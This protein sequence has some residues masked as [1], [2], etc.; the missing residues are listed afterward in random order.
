MVTLT[1]ADN[2]LKSLYLEALS[3]QLNTTTNPL[4]NK[5]VSTERD[6]WGKEIIKLAP[7]GMNGGI[8]AGTETGDLPASAGNNYKQFKQT[9]KNLYGTIEIS[10]KAIRASA[11]N[12]GAFLSLLDAEMDGLLAASKFNFGRMLF[13]SGN[14]VLTAVASVS[15]N[16]VVVDS[17]QYLMEGM[18][19]DFL[20]SGTAVTSYTGRRIT[21][22]DRT[23]CTITI[24]GTA[25]VEGE[26]V[27]D[28]QIT[29]QGSYNNELTGLEAIFDSDITSLYGL[30]KADNPWL[31]PYTDTVT[32]ITETEIQTVID[33][34]ESFSGSTADYIVC[35]YGV[36]R[37]YQAYMRSKSSNIEFTNLDGGFKALSYNGI[38]LVADRFCPANTM[39]IL[40]AKD[41]N[42]HQLCDW[43]W[44]EGEH[45]QVLK[46]IAG[47]PSY[48]ATLVKYADLICNKPNAQAKLTGITEA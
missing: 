24:S 13:G 20:H 7:Y 37:A 15:G 2:V 32:N 34:L 28:D 42:L 6:V 17:V 47:K 21:A 18:V 22:I 33:E 8:G 1:N 25:I 46:Q 23:T 19:V 40:S 29:L 4:Y 27:A 16:E 10:D 38:P 14:G 9:L 48:S 3:N 30:T 41:F 39:Y 43:R 26:I 36:R 44:L 45:G 35:S 31:K 11:N 5:F 12:S